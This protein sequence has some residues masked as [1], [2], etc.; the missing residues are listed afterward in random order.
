MHV[1][2]RGI[3]ELKRQSLQIRDLLKMIQWNVEWDSVFRLSSEPFQHKTNPRVMTMT[4]TSQYL[5]TKDR[6]FS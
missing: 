4:M 6:C 1:D 3:D 5:F 2:G